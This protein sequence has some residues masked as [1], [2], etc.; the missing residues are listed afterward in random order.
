LNGWLN[1]T[2]PAA[3]AGVGEATPVATS[4]PATSIVTAKT[5]EESRWPLLRRPIGRPTP[6]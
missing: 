4:V 5:R 6:G 3:W 2:V 1:S